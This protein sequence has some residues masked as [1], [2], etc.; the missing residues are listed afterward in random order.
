MAALAAIFRA[1][2]QSRSCDGGRAAPGDRARRGRLLGRGS[3]TNTGQAG[4]FACARAAQIATTTVVTE[5]VRNK[6]SRRH[7]ADDLAAGP[8]AAKAPA[9]ERGHADHPNPLELSYRS[10]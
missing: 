4:V 9:E 1:S 7:R 10:P 6:R 5:R 8:Q 2:A 3:P